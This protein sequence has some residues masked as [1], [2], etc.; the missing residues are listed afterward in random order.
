MAEQAE[1]PPWI[2]VRVPASHAYTIYDCY[3]G[4]IIQSTYNRNRTP[5]Y[6]PADPIQWLWL[7][8]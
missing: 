4:W 8:R 7:T 2:R 5:P 1:A 3:L 6:R